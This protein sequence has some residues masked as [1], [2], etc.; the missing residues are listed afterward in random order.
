MLLEHCL[1]WSKFS[2]NVCFLSGALGRSKSHH[3]E[4]SQSERQGRPTLVMSRMLDSTW[5]HSPGLSAPDSSPWTSLFSFFYNI[6]HSLTYYII[7]LV[8]V[9]IAF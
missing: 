3:S 7:C 8:I 1:A 9:F 4:G 6:Y 2:V 5:P